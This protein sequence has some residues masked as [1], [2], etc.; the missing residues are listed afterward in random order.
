MVLC[1]QLDRNA[2]KNHVQDCCLCMR[3]ASTLTPIGHLGGRSYDW[4]EGDESSHSSAASCAFREPIWSHCNY[5]HSLRPD[6]PP[7]PPP[8]QFVSSLRQVVIRVRPPLNGEIEQDVAV[9]AEE[10]NRVQVR[11]SGWTT[12]ERQHFHDWW[13]T[14]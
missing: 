13:A 10:S 1:G 7:C 4:L 5:P 12:R 8:L 6:L 9:T 14:K 3:P 11:L 2:Q